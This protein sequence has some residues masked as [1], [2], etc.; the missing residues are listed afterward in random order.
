MQQYSGVHLRGNTALVKYIIH[1][2]CIKGYVRLLPC[3]GRAKRMTRKKSVGLQG[4]EGAKWP[5]G[6]ALRPPV[7]LL[8]YPCTTER[9][10]GSQLVSQEHT[11]SSWLLL[12]STAKR[13]SSNYL[14]DSLK[15]TLGGIGRLTA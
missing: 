5:W 2:A 8:H 15:S 9:H 6:D 13:N 4:C 14:L 10:S 1:R 12:C 7:H 3:V 11:P